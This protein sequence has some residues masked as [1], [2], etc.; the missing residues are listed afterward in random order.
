MVDGAAFRRG[1]AQFAASVTLITS[2]GDAG[3]AGVTASSVTSVS[4]EP[5]IMLACLN[6]A[7]RTN[8]TIRA[9][10]VF[11][12]NVL[13]PKHQHLAVAFSGKAGTSLDERFGLA[14]WSRLESA[15]PVLA[16]CQ[17]ALDCRLVDEMIVGTHV[18]LF[19]QVVALA[20]G[21]HAPPLL[22]SSRAYRRLDLWPEEG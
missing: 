13:A 1:M 9:N 18:V 17:V 15:S 8:R 19:G 5:P 12:I 2:D 10:G 16:G 3:L 7:G 6:L 20:L 14:T 4:D 21:P 22:Y 11:C